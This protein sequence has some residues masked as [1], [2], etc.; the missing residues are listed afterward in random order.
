MAYYVGHGQIEKFFNSV[1]ERRVWVFPPLLRK[2]CLRMVAIQF[3]MFIDRTLRLKYRLKPFTEFL[4]THHF[5]KFRLI[6][7]RGVVRTPV[8]I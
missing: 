3:D 6:S 7:D 8:N 1:P 2:L 4:I 5:V